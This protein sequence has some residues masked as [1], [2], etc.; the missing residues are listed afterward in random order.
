MTY[1]DYDIDAA[2][3]A[4]MKFDYDMAQID[5]MAE[6]EQRVDELESLA[7]DMW[8]KN[9]GR[10][11]HCGWCVIGCEDEEHCELAERMDA[12]GLLEGGER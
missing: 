1:D 4:E 3:M 11:E 12:L 2:E 6:L 7:R 9:I 10:M 5:N 8:F